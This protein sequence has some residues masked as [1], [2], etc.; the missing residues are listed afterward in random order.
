MATQFAKNQ[1]NNN[2]SEE[3]SREKCIPEFNDDDVPPP[4]FMNLM[5]HVD[6]PQSIPVTASF[7]I[8]YNKLRLGKKSWQ[9]SWLKRS[10]VD[11]LHKFFVETSERLNSK[12]PAIKDKVPELQKISFQE[13]NLVYK[14]KIIQDNE[15]IFNIGLKEGHNV[16]LIFKTLAR[17]VVEEQTMD[18]SMKY[19]PKDEGRGNEQKVELSARQKRYQENIFGLSVKKFEMLVDTMLENPI[20]IVRYSENKMVQR[21]LDDKEI[22]EEI[23]RDVPYFA[24]MRK[25]SPRFDN[26]ISGNNRTDMDLCRSFISATEIIRPMMDN[27]KNSEHN[28]TQMLKYI[29][30]PELNLNPMENS[31]ILKPV[32]GEIQGDHVNHDADD[33]MHYK[34]TTTTTKSNFGNEPKGIRADLKATYKKYQTAYDQLI[35][36]GFAEPNKVLQALNETDGDVNGAINRYIDMMY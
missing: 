7:E 11:E 12:D 35:S 6:L 34:K 22:K 32:N 18:H 19:L 31:H 24:E 4:L 16:N 27:M 30:D 17:K 10:L 14:G 3:L 8:P 25:K 5:V 20:L 36:M 33:A 13:L 21:L 23:T 29:V 2:N 1:F 15:N 26:M 9:I 28:L